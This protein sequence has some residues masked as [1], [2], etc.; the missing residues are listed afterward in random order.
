MKPTKNEDKHAGK[1]VSLEASG[2]NRHGPEPERFKIEG[3][4]KNWEDAVKVALRKPKPWGG[5]SKK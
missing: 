4:E 1:P 3:Y 5:W 2:R